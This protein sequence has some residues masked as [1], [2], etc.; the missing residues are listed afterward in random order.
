MP[1]ALMCGADH[2]MEVALECESEMRQ[3]M[4]DPS[5]RDWFIQYTDGKGNKNG[6]VYTEH[7]TPYVLGQQFFWDFRVGAAQ[8]YFVQAVLGTV[9]TDEFVDGTVRP[10]PL[11]LDSL[12]V[13]LALVISHCDSCCPHAYPYQTH[14]DMLLLARLL[15]AGATV[16]FHAVVGV[17]NSSRMTHPASQLSILT[18]RPSPDSRRRK[19]RR[20][21]QRRHRCTRSSCVLW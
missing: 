21:R 19:S 11:S 9:A 20:C 5:K 13:D 7:L 10:S 3:V 17:G 12:D 4:N 1:R 6:T 14:T 2:N 18:R 8:D 15:T 16:C